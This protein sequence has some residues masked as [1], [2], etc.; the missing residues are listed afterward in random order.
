MLAY[1]NAASPIASDE[2][3]ARFADLLKAF[4]E[5]AGMNPSTDQLGQSMDFS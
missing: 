3:L 2:S 5:T 4:Q 1:V